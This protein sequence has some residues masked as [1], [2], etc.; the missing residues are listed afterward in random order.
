MT[1]KNISRALIRG[2]LKDNIYFCYSIEKISNDRYNRSHSPRRPSHYTGTPNTPRA[3]TLQGYSDAFLKTTSLDEVLKLK[4]LVGS[5]IRIL[6][7]F[8]LVTRKPWKS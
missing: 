1:A 2:E 4:K 7:A 3:V 6:T 5:L 8:L